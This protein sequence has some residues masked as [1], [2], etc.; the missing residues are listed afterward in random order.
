MVFSLRFEAHSEVGRI[1]KNNQDSGYA[2][3]TM[4]LVADGMGGAAAGDLASAVATTIA[5]DADAHVAG[6]EMLDHMQGI[7]ATANSRLAEL[8]SQDLT[9]D[10]MGTTFCGAMFDGEQLALTHIG[11]S[12]CYLLRDG[13][14]SQLTHD[15]SWVQQLMDEGRLTPEQAATHPH[16]SLILRVLNGQNNTSPDLE[17]VEVQ[18]GDRLLFCSDGLS[19]LIS[20]DQ[21]REFLTEDDL[22]LAIDDLTQAANEAGGHDNITVVLADVV[23]QDDALDAARPQLVGS[24]TE[25][26][27]P[28][29]EEEPASPPPPPQEL[30]PEHTG[31]EVARYA[32][33]PTS[34]RW[35]GVIAGTLAILLVLGGATWGVVAYSTSRYY[36][37]EAD[38]NVAIY[39]GLPGSLLGYELNVLAERSDIAVSDLPRF[40]QRAVSNTIATSDLVSAQESVEELRWKADRCVAVRQERLNQPGVSTPTPTASPSGLST[41][42]P[43]YPTYLAPITPT[44]STES[45]PEAC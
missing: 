34:R 23:E 35:P 28:D 16:R 43:N 31:D 14:L 19:G 45:D 20:D 1:R 33:E 17:L 15:H 37:S 39:N 30:T 21:I 42:Q 40:Y 12:R 9:L 10:G 38:G 27:I 2:S 26:E 25:R 11:D 32:P 36:I 29:V 22:D 44:A 5:R 41:G 24:A 18:L 4:L 6:A 8:V 3:P 7:L 13:A